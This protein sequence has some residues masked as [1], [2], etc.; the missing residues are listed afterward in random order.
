MWC[1]GPS[2]DRIT[3]TTTLAHPGTVFNP[4]RFSLLRCPVCGLGL[5]E[6]GDGGFP[7]NLGR[8]FDVGCRHGGVCPSQ[9]SCLLT[10]TLLIV[11]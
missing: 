11:C 1:L 5:A 4:P 7:D 3:L 10:M 2:W 8:G 6:G 9:T